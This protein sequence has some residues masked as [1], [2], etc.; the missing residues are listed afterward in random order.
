MGKED[1]MDGG[2]LELCI[3]NMLENGN[4]LEDESKAILKE[5]IDETELL[6]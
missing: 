5:L 2:K 4:F 3:K 1:N 6:I